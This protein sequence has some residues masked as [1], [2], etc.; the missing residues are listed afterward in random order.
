M[1]AMRSL[2]IA[3]ILFAA[4][5]SQADDVACA[6]DDNVNTCVRRLVFDYARTLREGAPAA[7][8]ASAEAA[9]EAASNSAEEN[10]QPGTATAGGQTASG[11]TD[12]LPWLNM[13]GLLSDSDESDGI[14]AFDLNFL[15]M[16]NRDAEA[17]HDSQLKWQLD[18]SPTLFEPLAQAIPDERSK[19][20]QDDIDE[21]ADSTLEYTYSV[22]NKHLGRD[23]RQHQR[24][25]Q[26][27]IAP[28]I[29]SASRGASAGEIKTAFDTKQAAFGAQLAQLVQGLNLPAGVAPGADKSKVPVQQFTAD[30]RARIDE[31][32]RNARN[33]YAQEMARRLDAM[34]LAVSDPR[35]YRMAELVLQQPQVLVTAT[36]SIRDELV[37]PESWGVKVTYEK[38]FVDFNGFRKFAGAGRAAGDKCAILDQSAALDSAEALV[39]TDNCLTALDAYVDRYA[40][41]IDNDSRWNV[42]LQYTQIDDWRYALPDDGVDLDLP[43]HDRLIASAGFGRA[44]QRSSA[45]DRVDFEAAYDSNMGDDETYNS[46][47]VVT[48]TYTRRIMDMDMPIS[49]TYANKSEFLGDT[50]KQIGMHIGIKYRVDK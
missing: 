9:A 26:A 16:R 39:A 11:V 27:L 45:K 8:D 13:L 48:L 25:F 23:F 44:I 24:E 10:A 42:S 46:R 19:A 6:P 14:I 22:I 3:C 2:A 29:F 15:L 32:V 40:E 28:R 20:L 33:E 12:L 17:R 50:D 18:V 41:Q 31:F 47:F 36:K 30:E 37:G 35:I 4:A 1:K 34:Q 49:I 21:T 38:S 5:A 43:K 7:A